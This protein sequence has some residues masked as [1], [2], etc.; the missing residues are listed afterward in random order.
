MCSASSCSTLSILRINGKLYDRSFSQLL[1]PWSDVDA[2]RKMQSALVPI[3]ESV[4]R[5]DKVNST[6]RED[7]L[8]LPGRTHRRPH[9]RRSVSI[10]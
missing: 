3:K 6:S 5:D 10:S 8:I 2:E 9:Q 7:R 4:A 1:W